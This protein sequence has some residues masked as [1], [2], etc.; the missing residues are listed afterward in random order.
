MKGMNL[1]Q[2]AEAVAEFLWPRQELNPN[3]LQELEEFIQKK[4]EQI[5][6]CV[7]WTPPQDIT[8]AFEF[9][10]LLKK[11]GVPECGLREVII[12]ENHVIH[13]YTDYRKSAK[14]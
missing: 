14:L 8:I 1:M 3:F 9:R 6:C 12:N 7:C 2:Y 11:Y 13:Y 10:S 5:Q 4:L